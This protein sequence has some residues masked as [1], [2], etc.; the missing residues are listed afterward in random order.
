MEFLQRSDDDVDLVYAVVRVMTASI[1][2]FAMVLAGE[3]EPDEAK[4]Q[5]VAAQM[6]RQSINDVD[7]TAQPRRDD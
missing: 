7:F 2:V 3:R 5:D 4:R 6:I 1:N